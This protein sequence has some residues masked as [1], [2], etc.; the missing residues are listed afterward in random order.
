VGISVR[1]DLRCGRLAV[2]S[3]YP[4][5]VAELVAVCETGSVVEFLLFWGHRPRRDGSAGSG[6]LSQWWPAPFI[7][8]GLTF[9]TAEHYMMWRK[10]MTFGDTHLAGQ[11]VAAPD[12]RRAKELGRRVAGFDEHTW[13]E[14]RYSVVVAGNLAKFNQHPDLAQILLDTGDRVLVEASPV[15]RVWGIGLAANDL[16]AT[17]PSRWRGR[18]LLGFALMDVRASLRTQ[19][20]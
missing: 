17:D 5:T 3:G 11:I 12:P 6:C 2:V 19:R 15:D 8:E 14:R 7:A 13:N 16:R 20:P 18:N 10:A 1:L 4:R 9:A